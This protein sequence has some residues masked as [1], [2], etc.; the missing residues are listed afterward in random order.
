[1]RTHKVKIYSKWFAWRWPS[2]SCV[3]FK[4]LG[5]QIS[6]LQDILE[7]TYQRWILNVKTLVLWVC[8]E[9]HVACVCGNGTQ[10]DTVWV[11]CISCL[12]LLNSHHKGNHCALNMSDHRSSE[13]VPDVQTKQIRS[14]SV[15][16]SCRLNVAVL[17]LV[18][19]TQK[20]NTFSE[21]IFVFAV[22]QEAG[23]LQV[24]SIFFFF[25]KEKSWFSV[26][27]KE[28][29]DPHLYE[30]ICQIPCFLSSWLQDDAQKIQAGLIP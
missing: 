21:W 29:L 27:S 22:L 11:Q 5:E 28:L 16:K 25:Y 9:P 20:C 4:G 8:A 12:Y 13:T 17:C 19:I 7:E 14:P 23:E 6:S 26:S 24:I 15:K 30:M 3:C 18:G 10:S 2:W 1:M